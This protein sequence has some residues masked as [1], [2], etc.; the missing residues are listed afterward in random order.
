MSQIEYTFASREEGKKLL[1]QNKEFFDS[2]TQ[3]DLEFKMQKTGVTLA[4]YRDF[5]AAQVLEFTDKDKAILKG[6]IDT[7]EQR[8]R[9]RKVI[10]PVKPITFIKTTMVEEGGADAYTHGYQIYVGDVLIDMDPEKRLEEV[11]HEIW[12]CLSQFNPDLRRRMYSLIGFK[13]QPRDYA[14][15]ASVKEFFITNPDVK[16]HDACAV[17]NIQG[18]KTEC[19][20]AV[21]TVC[22]YENCNNESFFPLLI[23]VLVLTDGSNKWTTFHNARD[24]DKVFGANT[25]YTLDPEE[26]MADN[27][28]YAMCYGM[29][30]RN[31]KGYPTPSII[32]GVLKIFSK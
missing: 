17:F 28:A 12:H 2:L 3:N 7:L 22:H 16:H 24:L 32:E 31:G 8:L 5:A 9:D 10:L 25:Q 27:F 29:K 20:C 13:I 4:Q 23:P 14:L 6:T 15:P 26:C 30:G 18:M 19:F 21:R 1:L 11:T